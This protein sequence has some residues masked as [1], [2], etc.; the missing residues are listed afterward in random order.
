MSDNI[1]VTT[2]SANNTQPRRGKGGFRGKG[3]KHRNNSNNNENDTA[4]IT[5]L[6]EASE[7]HAAFLW[8]LLNDKSDIDKS[9]IMVL[10]KKLFTPLLSAYCKYCDF[11]SVGSIDDLIVD[12]LPFTIIFFI[13]TGLPLTNTTKNVELNDNQIVMIVHLINMFELRWISTEGKAI[14]KETL[15][16]F[17]KDLADGMFRG[18]GQCIPKLPVWN[19]LLIIRF[20]RE[21]A[22]LTSKTTLDLMRCQIG[23]VS[24]VGC[25]DGANCHGVYVTNNGAEGYKIDCPFSHPDVHNA[26]CTAVHTQVIGSNP[27]PVQNNTSPVQ[28]NTSPVQNNTSPVQN[29]TSPVPQQRTN[30]VFNQNRLLSAQEEKIKKLEE[31]LTNMQQ[32]MAQTQPQQQQQTQQTQQHTQQ[33]QHTQTKPHK[34]HNR[35]TPQICNYDGRCTNPM[36]T[37]LHNRCIDDPAIC[38]RLHC[39][40]HPRNPPTSVFHPHNPPQPIFQSPTS[41]FQS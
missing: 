34:K 39:A 25:P 15:E 38:N 24:N 28:N 21:F 22:L 7:N 10:T 4:L 20:Q 1:S 3:N 16:M 31:Q 40:T 2:N 18:L 32:T 29:N 17:K 27:H 12:N 36:C 13:I 19:P 11:M 37:Y 5:K 35:R 8:T 9:D 23:I 30:Q 14:K 41:I 26:R 33:H 6:K